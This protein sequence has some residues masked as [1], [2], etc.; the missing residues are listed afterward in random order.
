MRKRRVGL[1]GVAVLLIVSCM[2]AVLLNVS[3]EDYKLNHLHDSHKNIYAADNFTGLD[4]F[5]LYNPYDID[6]NDD[7]AD[8]SFWHFIDSSKQSN[9]ALITFEDAN[10]KSV[11]W[12]V[13]PCKNNQH[14]A[15][16]TP[17]S[18]K[19]MDGVSYSS[20]EGNF[21]LSHS[22]RHIGA[23]KVNVNASVLSY[24]YEITPHLYYERAVDEYYDRTVDE[25][26][27]RTV[28]E[29]YERTVDE[30]Y[31]RSVTDYFERPVYEIY[32]R[33]AQK[34]LVPVFTR[35]VNSETGTLVTRLT[36]SDNTKKAKPVNG[37]IF[38]N[39]HTYVEI[40]VDKASK[41]GGVWYTI[42]DSSKNNG[43]KTPSQYNRPIDYKY[44]VQIKDGKLTIS[45]DDELVSAS[46]GAYVVAD[47]SDFPGN[48]PKHYNNSVTVNLP[49]N[50]G[51]VY[52]YTHIS[53]IS[54]YAGENEYEFLEWR[55][56]DSRTVYDT[57]YTLIDTKKGEYEYVR[58]EK[59]EYKLVDKVYGDYELVDTKYGDYELVDTKYG[60]Y[61]LV[62][63]KY[64]KVKKD[65]EYNGELV[66]TVNGEV[67]PL[68]EELV[69]TPGEY[70]FTV[71]SANNEFEPVSKVVTILPGENDS[72]NFDI[73]YVLD[74]VTL[75]SVEHKSDNVIRH[76]ADKEAT[77]H[78]KDLEATVHKNDKKAT[79]HQ[80]DLETENIYSDKEI[81]KIYNEDYLFKNDIKLGNDK[82]PFG[83]YSVRL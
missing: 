63:T 47:P 68:D 81:E 15:V 72:I 3:A 70:T 26:Y 77:I 55:Y 43:K 30:Y 78:Q 17:S 21:V 31:E 82:D 40:D 36:Y 27:E 59:G 49:K 34:Y 64:D 71:S 29:Y 6:V 12:N 46:V 35:K 51:T 56:D 57:D 25:Y 1:I 9:Y 7:N 23:G 67:K 11:T 41:D 69:L 58:T 8:Y 44:N 32:N 4:D 20:G 22:G 45:F 80:K 62:D 14:Y 74:D 75:A 10:G 60:N 83:E 53:S 18:W 19:L 38:N 5:D 79:I 33:Y 24:Y 37:G 16:I 2:S 42:A 28:D 39:G 50:D 66:L 48:A 52:L 61:E 13:K 65:V 76:E 73:L 54:W